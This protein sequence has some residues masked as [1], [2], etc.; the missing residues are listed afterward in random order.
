MYVEPLPY[1]K[2]DQ[3]Q[4]FYFFKKVR[5]GVKRQCFNGNDTLTLQI[6]KACLQVTLVDRQG[7]I[8]HPIHSLTDAFL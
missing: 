1:S 7:W 8:S 2:K 3:Q 6:V 5:Y 4:G